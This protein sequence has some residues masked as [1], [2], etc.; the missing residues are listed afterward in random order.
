MLAA[1]PELGPCGS[2]PSTPRRL[3]KTTF[4]GRLAALRDAG[5][6]GASCA[7]GISGASVAE[8]HTDDL[9][10]GWTDILNFWPRLGEWILDPLSRG[11]PGRYR[12][13][14]WVAGRFGD[15]W[16]DVP[17]P[18]VLLVEGVASAR[19]A[20]RPRLTLW[21]FVTAAPDVRLRRGIARDGEELREQWDAGCSTRTGT[22]RPTARPRE[23]ISSR[24]RAHD[25]PDP[26]LEFV[27]LMPPASSWAALDTVSSTR[28]IAVGIRGE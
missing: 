2:W 5:T 18:D 8:I 6:S 14:D 25:R 1:R 12:R 21:A 19:T 28:T 3:G 22:S 23:R 11:E 4:A 7:S 26:A 10:E 27:G 24:R 16:L 17:V 15:E 20:I 13:Y 9:L